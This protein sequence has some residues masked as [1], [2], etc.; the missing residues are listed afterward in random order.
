[1]TLRD[2][3]LLLNIIE[4]RINYGLEIDR[5]TLIEF[6]DKSKHLNYIFAPNV[7]QRVIDNHN[8][9]INPNRVSYKSLSQIL[10]TDLHLV[11][12]SIITM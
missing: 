5:S 2:L 6:K 4:N 9:P 7:T 1:M 10:I 12:I 8:F 3:K 11:T